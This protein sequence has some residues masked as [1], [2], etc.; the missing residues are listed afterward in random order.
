MS[1]AL[2][3]FTNVA[4]AAKPIG[5]DEFVS[6]FKATLAAA[7][8]R[9]R[10]PSCYIEGDDARAATALAISGGADSMALAAM[11]R[12]YIYPDHPE[13]LPAFIVNHG[14]RQES[15]REAEQV[16]TFLQEKLGIR[17]CV[18]NDEAP[19][20]V[21]KRLR[22]GETYARNLRF[23]LL[24]SALQQRSI[25]RIALAHHCNDQHE[26]ILQRL[27][28]GSRAGLTGIGPVSSLAMLG[29]HRHSSQLPL[30]LIT[31]LWPSQ[32]AGDVP[33]ND[34][35][36]V[37]AMM[38]PSTTALRPLLN[39][40]KS[41]L[42]ATCKYFGME[43]VEDRT[44]EDPTFT[45]RNAIRK[46]S[47][48]YQLPKALTLNSIVSLQE[49]LQAA[50][51]QSEAEARKLFDLCKLD[52]DFRS[53]V[54]KVA[55]PV[56]EVQALRPS[57]KITPT[58]AGLLK[59]CFQ[60][61][62]RESGIIELKDLT[63]AAK[64]IFDDRSMTDLQ[65]HEEAAR[66][67]RTALSVAYRPTTYFE[68]PFDLD[69]ADQDRWNC[70]TFCR[71]GF[72]SSAVR[73]AL[74]DHIGPLACKLPLRSA[75]NA[76][77]AALPTS[78][79]KRFHLWDGRFWIHA[80]LVD[81]PMGTPGHLLIRPLLPADL[82]TFRQMCDREDLDL[83]LHDAPLGMND[84]KMRLDRILRSCAPGKI[85]YTLPV[86]EYINRDQPTQSSLLALPTLGLTFHAK[87]A[88][89]GVSRPQSI[90]HLTCGNFKSMPRL[91]SSVVYRNAYIG[92]RHIVTRL[93]QEG[94]HMD[95]RL[96][97]E[98]RNAATSD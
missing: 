55:F 34:Q 1:R 42:I 22:K 84:I 74:K 50:S 92:D 61:V 17:A 3:R 69:A 10:G 27:A 4:D 81:V 60:I 9:L 49:K 6:A 23:R 7:A 87:D 52:V 16:R 77:G 95:V 65:G 21:D 48:N 8:A 88:V 97:I 75:S 45:T 12:F 91:R 78:H 73:Q 37:F 62:R 26:T 89:E 36:G 18:L 64:H 63:S 83:L 28:T 39:F 32:R 40:P 66:S 53:G 59:L 85:R 41:R 14:M 56:H 51:D 79:D 80:E 31:P 67:T 29:N 82:T 2:R 5:K 54:L 98:S 44:N 96:C 46:I 90:P 35:C 76:K 47:R 43:W 86:I 58:L 15:G 11:M 68:R 94:K 13:R 33:T 38:S 70:W 57:E 24:E 30:K 25:D 71:S 72:H 20:K 93:I 19:R